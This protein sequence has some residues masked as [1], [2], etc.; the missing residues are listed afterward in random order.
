MKHDSIYDLMLHNTKV[1]TIDRTTGQVTIFKESLVPKDLYLETD[2]DA[3]LF[4]NR[5]VFNWWCANR[6]LSLDRKYAKE[7]LNSCGLKQATTDRDRADIALQCKCLSLRDFFWVKQDSDDSKWEKVNLFDNSLSNAVVD[8]ALKGKA[9]SVTN[10]ELIQSD[11][12][13]DGLFPKAWYR[14]GKD[15][16]LYKGDVND[17]VN[18][19]VAAT[20]ILKS[21]GIPVLDYDSVLYKGEKVSV[22]KCF[23]NKNLGYVTAENM[24]VGFAPILEGEGQYVEFVNNRIKLL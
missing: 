1:L 5:E 12:S 10:Q 19:E 3:D 16:Y 6:I 14:E 18:K 15:F 22:S 4:N 7:L 20:K 23:T 13:T 9:L 17:S 2:Y 24:I 11:I 8:I 21:L